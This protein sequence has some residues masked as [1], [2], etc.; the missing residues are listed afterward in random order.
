MNPFG[1]KKSRLQSMRV[2]KDEI[3]RM[4]PAPSA[5]VQEAFSQCPSCK[6]IIATRVMRGN[7]M[8]CPAC[9]HYLILSAPDRLRMTFDQGRYFELNADLIG[10]DPLGFPGYA[11]KLEAQRA[12]TGLAEAVV[13]AVGCIGGR[14]AVVA[15][16]DSR[17][18]MG[19]MGTAVGERIT[20]AVEYATR[21]KL[22]LVIFSASGGAR[23][24][25]GIFSLMQMAK[26]S[27]AVARHNAA[28]LLFVS[29]MTHP[30]T[31][32][33]T[34]SFASL[35]DVIISEPHALIGFAGPRV[36]EQTI[37]QK[38]PEGFQRAESLL[39]DG[40]LDAV[41]ERRDMRD[42]LMRILEFADAGSRRAIC[43]ADPESAGGN[44]SESLSVTA[45]DAPDA[46]GES[47]LDGSPEQRLA[48]ARDAHRPHADNLFEALFSDF[49]ELH[50]D[51]RFAD[52]GSILAGIG[53]FHGIPVMA[54]GELKGH[55]VQSNIACN[56][57]MPQPE[58]YRKAERLARLAGKFRR[59]VIT[60]IDT[61]GAYPG[62]EAERRGQAEAIAS[63]LAA[64]SLIPSPVVA[65]VIGEGGS[66]GAL[67]LGVADSVIMLENAV[68]AVLSPEGFA[69]I[70][71]KDRARAPEACRTMRITAADLVGF[72]VADRMV[73]EGPGGAQCNCEQV[74]GRLD[75]AL[76]EELGALIGLDAPCLVERRYRRFR[77]FGEYASYRVAEQPS[78][79][80]PVALCGETS[81]AVPDGANQNR[82]VGQ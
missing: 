22:S 67:A 26:T 35:G 6:R 20:R 32:G 72:H 7:G 10:C 15:V 76:A 1:K 3:R 14:K 46:D 48:L 70:L 23:M 54:I 69:A 9:G 66:G 57:G 55:D 43:P 82:E 65:V 2:V 68:Y 77:A 30:T 45:P 79:A 56:F 37:G 60:F 41:V 61:P 28:G 78:A 39:R 80:P 40:F 63:C 52:D 81:A 64:F 44:A 58:G 71:W 29:V 36:I 17:F 18:L 42:A 27:A 25:E 21:K 75:R 8:V 4:R 53:R 13:C 11:D 62:I 73:P 34:A 24:Q 31:G 47:D 50:G 33:V 49:F 12:R 19:S 51:R 38:L 74:V 16:L 59:P 5:P